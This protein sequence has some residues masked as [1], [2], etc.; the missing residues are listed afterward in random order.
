MLN[1][2]LADSSLDA[3]TKKEVQ[4]KIE[5]I[6]RIRSDYSMTRAGM[7]KYLDKRV[8]NFKEAELDKWL[9]EGRFD[10]MMI[11]GKQYFMGASIS[12]LLYRYPDV[13]NRKK[14]KS[15]D[16][17]DEFLWNNY[18]KILAA[19]ADN[20][21]R[22]VDPKR[23]ECTFTLKVKPNVVPEG[24]MIRC[25]MPFP[26]AIPAQNDIR[27]LEADPVP[28]N[29]DRPDSPIR[30]LYF[31]QPSMGSEP[32]EFKFVFRY[33]SFAILNQ[34]DY[35]KVLPLPE[36]H[37][38]RFY[39]REQKHVKFTPE[40]KTLAADIVGSETNPY[41]QMRQIYNWVAD[42]ILYSYAREYS[43]L[44]NISMYCYEKGYGDCGQEALLFITLCRICGIPAHWES[45]WVMYP[46]YVGIHDWTKVYIEPYGWI[47]VDPFM[48]V[49]GTSGQYDLEDE[50]IESLRNFYCG[51]LDQYR[52]R[53]NGDHCADLYPPKTSFRS[54][55]VDF[56]RGEVEWDGGNIYFGQY[57]RSMKVKHL[58]EPKKGRIKLKR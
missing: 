52:F 14:D 55:D 30:S 45:G 13:R 21:D 38:A 10:T 17:W 32:T 24:K 18:L 9:K 58:D 26:K 2:H 36:Q 54:D 35:E 43:T 47:P 5:L 19:G 49:W 33:T 25:W 7:I 16:P 6:K 1:S 20:V 23:M 15:P 27:L 53:A 41:L 42:S 3:V 11:D 40:L 31:E 51:N 48:A 37:P 39:L 46:E 56:Q 28:L 57:S 44:D 12:N 34:I 22:H 29:L 8:E 4:W 50:Q